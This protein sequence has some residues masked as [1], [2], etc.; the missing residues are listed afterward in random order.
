MTVGMTG[1]MLWSEAME[2]LKSGEIKREQNSSSRLVILTRCQIINS[3]NDDI[4][5]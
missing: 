1:R 3:N 4:E 5:H 2:S